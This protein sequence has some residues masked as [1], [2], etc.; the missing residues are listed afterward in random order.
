MDSNNDWDFLDKKRTLP[1]SYKYKPEQLGSYS[2]E[3]P[4]GAAPVQGRSGLMGSSAP[5]TSASGTS[6]GGLLG[7]FLKPILNKGYEAIKEKITQNPEAPAAPSL[8]EVPEIPDSFYKPIDI[9][10]PLRPPTGFG[11]PFSSIPNPGYSLTNPLPNYP[12]E[13]FN[14]KNYEGTLYDGSI[15]RIGEDFDPTLNYQKPPLGSGLMDKIKK[16]FSLVNIGKGIYDITQGAG[17]KGGVDLA[18]GIGSSFVPGIGLAKGAF[19]LVMGIG[20][21]IKGR[22]RQYNFYHPYA[23]DSI[24]DKGGLKLTRLNFEDSDEDALR[25]YQ[26]NLKA[27]SG[28]NFFPGGDKYN[29][30]QLTQPSKNSYL[31]QDPESGGMYWVDPLKYTGMKSYFDELGLGDDRLMGFVGM[32]GE[33]PALPE[34]YSQL[35]KDWNNRINSM[36]LNDMVTNGLN[37]EHAGV[38]K[39]QAGPFGD[40][41]Y[42]STIPGREN[43]NSLIRMNE[44]VDMYNKATTVMDIGDYANWSDPGML[45]PIWKNTGY[46]PAMEYGI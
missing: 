27:G 5:V 21:Y 15:G 44:L 40:K 12:S 23:V 43:L 31:V 39:L 14:P 10:L 45:N 4:K 9:K 25:K 34:N 16:G 8:P 7:S 24:Q 36:F 46:N 32:G 2:M 22:G 30:L 37:F 28:G 13:A 26:E 29:D 41:G 11:D 33:S 6:Y 18:S 20:Q 35:E 19:D 1:L 38:S 17:G 3:G 42:V